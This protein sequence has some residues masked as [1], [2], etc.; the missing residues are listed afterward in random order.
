MHCVC[1]F[2]CAHALRVY[3]FVRTSSNARVLP[4][5]L[6]IN[7]TSLAVNVYA[8]GATAPTLVNPNMS[9]QFTG[10]SYAT[11]QATPTTA[12]GGN[13]TQTMYVPVLY[14]SRRRFVV[15]QG[16]P[17]VGEVHQALLFKAGVRKETWQINYD[18]GLCQCSFCILWAKSHNGGDQSLAQRHS[19]IHTSP[20]NPELALV[21]PT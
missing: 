14:A 1:I 7:K 15:R 16:H 17:A 12:S 21:V 5:M 3:I 19:H 13:V 2:L 4:H 11:L 9:G 8:D 10:A 18:L 6:L 20:I